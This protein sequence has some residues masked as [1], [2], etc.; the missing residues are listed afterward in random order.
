[1]ADANPNEE[2]EDIVPPEVIA[3][4][5]MVG[6]AYGVTQAKPKPFAAPVFTDKT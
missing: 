4:A 5:P 1:M 6:C 2:I 3:V